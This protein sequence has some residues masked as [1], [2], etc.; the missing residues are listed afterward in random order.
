MR[1]LLAPDAY[2]GTLTA[3]EAAAAMAAG[4]RRV[5]PAAEI[6]MRPMADGGE[7]TLEVLRPYL[8][9][10]V[11][12]RRIQGMNGRMMVAP[13]LAFMDAGREPAWL[14]ESARAV[15][16]TLP[17]TLALPPLE[18]SSVPLG[19]LL[20]RGFEEGIRRFY[21]ALGGSACNDG[22]I[23]LLSACG[24]RLLDAAGAELAPLLSSMRLAARVDVSRLDS[25]LPEVELHLILDVDNPL[26]GVHGATRTYGPQKGLDDG[27]LHRAE[28]WM[29]RWADLA[30]RAFGRRV[31]RR[32]GAGAAGGLGFALM[33]LG[34]KSHA[35]AAWVARKNGLAPA[36]R[37]CDWVLTG[38]GRS[39]AQTLHGK[40]PLVVAKLARR[41][42]VRVALMSGTIE[43]REEFRE[44]FDARF[45][46]AE[47]D[48]TPAQAGKRAAEHLARRTGEFVRRLGAEKP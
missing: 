1:F 6:V 45:P 21:I 34:A 37:D 11:R 40:A 46:L 16:I 22:G 24:M 12:T 28:A 20:E 29:R 13:V 41:A 14:I 47:D 26:L 32:A 33:L 5:D 48:R 19:T 42:G 39:D 27:D 36:L 38:E 3:L 35:G 44:L 30:E 18:R 2:K 8:A 43:E 23:G 17:A 15:G 9:G 4:I 31:R 7:G 25:R 10:Q